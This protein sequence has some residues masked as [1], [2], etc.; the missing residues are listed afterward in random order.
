MCDEG[1]WKHTEYSGKDDQSRAPD[2]RVLLAVL[3]LLPSVYVVTMVLHGSV[4]GSRTHPPILDRFRSCNLECPWSVAP[5]NRNLSDE[6]VG[7]HMVSFAGYGRT[8]NYVMSMRN[9]INLAFACRKSIMLPLVDDSGNAFRVNASFSLLDFSKVGGHPHQACASLTFPMSGNARLFWNLDENMKA[10]LNDHLES[11]MV[12]TYGKNGASIL[13]VCIKKYLGICDDEYCTFP[14]TSVLNPME[15]DVL[16][17]HLREGDIFKENFDPD[18]HRNY[19]Q[20]PVSYYLQAL[21]F[22]KWD[23]AI[24]VTQPGIEGPIRQSLL[25]G[26][27]SMSTALYIQMAEW[28]D[29]LRTCLCAANLV[30][31]KSTLESVFPL[32]FANTI[33]SYRCLQNNL[34]DKHIYQISLSDE[35]Q[36]FEFHDNS[37]EEWVET[38]LHI[39]HKPSLC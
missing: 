30:T 35:Y 36:P 19:G 25:L 4:L 3:L 15:G 22:K 6:T 26:N 13:E 33:F 21:T 27:E 14:K 10:I 2:R 17:M 20:P 23:K 5:T 12:H 16:V 29:D 11:N 31:S 7:F 28:Y 37:P 38:L 18:V 9:A 34:K 24:I 32:G 1:L 8:G 39:S